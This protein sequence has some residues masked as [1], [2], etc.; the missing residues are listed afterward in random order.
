MGLFLSSQNATLII[1]SSRT[2]SSI[3]NLKTLILLHD[4]NY[5]NWQERHQ[6]SVNRFIW[7]KLNNYLL[8]ICIPLILFGG[9][10]QKEDLASQYSGNFDYLQEN[11]LLNYLRKFAVKNIIY[12]HFIPMSLLRI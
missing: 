8:L 5:I 10:I 9:F 12:I 6:L 4:K 3:N 1:N 11:I 2:C 7:L